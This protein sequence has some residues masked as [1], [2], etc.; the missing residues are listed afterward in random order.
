METSPVLTPLDQHCRKTLNPLLRRNILI[1][2]T[3]DEEQL[4]DGL[5]FILLATDIL[6]E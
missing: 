2:I 3:A 6:E 4:T 1:A 5:G